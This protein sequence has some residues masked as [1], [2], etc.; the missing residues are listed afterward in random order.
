GVQDPHFVDPKPSFIRLLNQ[1][2]LLIDGGID[3]EVGW[4]PPLL[5][6]ARNGK[7][8]TGSPGR[9]VASTGVNILQLPTRPVER[10]QGDVHPLGNPHYMLDPEN[11]KI[12]AGEIAAA[13]CRLDGRSCDSYRKNQAAFDRRLDQKMAEWTQAMTP[14]RG[15]KIITYHDSWPYFAG[16]FGLKVVGQ[17]E[18]KPGVPP[19][20]AHLKGLIETAQQQKVKAILMEPFYNDQAPK[21]VAAQTGAKLLVLPATVAPEMGI[22]DYVQLFDHLVAALTEALR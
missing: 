6:G 18:P 12:V 3:L 2:D 19:S 1:A 9:I 5:E 10:S 22:N 16:R 17:I 15:A 7:I 11:G 20:T 4:L 8:Q 13:L 14:Y 21:F